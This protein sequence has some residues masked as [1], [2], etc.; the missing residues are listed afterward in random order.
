MSEP[1]FTPW[2]TWGDVPDDIK[3]QLL[4]GPFEWGLELGARDRFCDALKKIAAAMS[5]LLLLCLPARAITNVTGNVQN[6]GTGAAGSFVRFYLRG[7]AGNQPRVDGVSVIAPTLGNV[8]YFD[9]VAAPN[10]FI[11]GQLY[12]TRDI[13]GN[14]GGDIEC[15]GSNTAVWYGMQLYQNGRGGPETPIHA[16]NATTLNISTVT[17]ITSNPMPMPA[18]T[19]S[20]TVSGCNVAAQAG[21]TA[22]AQ[23]TAC[24]S[25]PGC[26][27]SCTLD[28]SGLAGTQVFL[29]NPFAGIER[30]I[31]FLCAAN[32]TWNISSLVIDL[33]N[34]FHLFGYQGCIISPT[35]TNLAATNQTDTAGI[36]VTN[37]VAL[38]GL[39]DNRVYGTTGSITS[40]AN[41][42]TVASSTGMRV[43]SAIGVMGAAGGSA[44]QQTTINQGGGIGAADTTVTLTSVTGFPSPSGTGFLTTPNYNYILIDSEIIGYSNASGSTLQSLTRGNFGTSAASHLNGATVQGLL[45]L[46]SE[47]TAIS[48]NT[49]TLLDN[50]SFTVT[51]AQVQTGASNI[52][53]DG[54]VTL[55]CLY[56]N[57][58]TT[59]NPKS[60]GISLTLAAGVTLADSVK[61]RQCQHAGVFMVASRKNKIGGQF[62]T[63]GRP[64]T[65][66]G[67]DVFTFSSS[68]NRINTV[69]HDDGSYMLILDDR[70]NEF[71]RY[72]GSSSNNQV[73]LGPQIGGG[74]WGGVTIE[75]GS[76]GNTVRVPSF[77]CS[78]LGIF[79]DTSGQ[80]TTDPNMTNNRVDFD[81]VDCGSGQAVQLAQTGPATIT[82]SLLLGG[83]ILNGS[84]SDNTSTTSAFKN[85]LLVVDGN[86]SWGSAKAFS[87]TPAIGGFGGQAYLFSMFR[88]C[89]GACGDLFG[90]TTNKY[91]TLSGWLDGTG[92]VRVAPA[93]TFP[94]TQKFFTGCTGTAS[95][96][97]TLLMSWAGGACT[98]TATTLQVPMT[99]AATAKNLRVR[100]S[101][102]GVNSSSGVFTLMQNGGASALTCTTGT[103]TTCSDT[104]HTVSLAAADTLL[105]QFTTQGAETLANCAAS[106]EVQ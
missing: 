9:F 32:F 90:E 54:D 15:G 86:N 4:Q 8:Y 92:T 82:G 65:G 31:T 28:A 79:L 84:V 48:G 18:I 53:I 25:S 70:S 91:L 26:A 61:M 100:C 55:D 93:S 30:P 88:Q 38:G 67:S 50:A 35:T 40:G 105:M 104:T 97:S 64:A 33:P 45:A 46:V 7:C 85:V 83:K 3:A 57:R 75:G 19:V 44:N 37:G 36:G 13:S 66:L 49:I 42:L 89:L 59:L 76:S 87:T 16:L 29:T 69:S 52:T 41:T 12:S 6:L 22:D 95:A 47:I 94:S 21:A 99:V 23:I 10:G 62:K 96:S 106:F 102:G 20:T 72:D 51:S 101:A 14:F 24:L 60:V 2:E 81:Q 27:T 68:Y 77:K 98:N 39:L 71:Y 43:G 17:P 80:W 34:D 1:Q 103:G 11:S 74:Y 63:L 5:I 58:A 78:N 73:T 56:T